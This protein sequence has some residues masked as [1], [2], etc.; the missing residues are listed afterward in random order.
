MTA[1]DA[2]AGRP[3]ANQGDAQGQVLC[4]EILADAERQAQRTRRRAKRD[5]D[6]A[7]KEAQ[8]EARKVRE[9]RLA[10]ARDEACRARDLILAR[11]GVEVARLRAARTEQVLREVRD[12]GQQ[13]L[14]GREGFDYRGRL[15]ALASEAIGAMEGRRFVL[16]LAAADL[17]AGAEGLAEEV[18][19]RVGRDDIEV[20]VS[21]DPAKIGA[22]VVVR[23][24]EGRQV[25]DNSFEA[26][27]DRLWPE[28]RLQIA[29]RLL[30]ATGQG[31]N[32]DGGPA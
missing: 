30:A 26:R 9:Q 1:A 25:W 7:L 18:R 17:E 4:K 6:A 19:R 31:E 3:A 5:A 29:K 14:A 32:K 22:G 10:D 12:G 8:A 28:L 15:A 16:E 27:L 2:G 24:A 13:R 21:P 20:T 11:V 23:D